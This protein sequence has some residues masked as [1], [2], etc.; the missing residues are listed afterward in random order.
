MAKGFFAK[1]KDTYLQAVFISL[2]NDFKLV[3]YCNS[4]WAGAWIIRKTHM[5]LFFLWESAAFIWPS[6]SNQL[7]R[8]LFVKLSIFSIAICTCFQTI[9][10]KN[11]LKKL[12]I[13]RKKS[14]WRVYGQQ[15]DNSINKE[16]CV[17]WPK[18]A[19]RHKT[20]FHLENV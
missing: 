8:S 20:S 10:Q 13:Y 6:R 11:L 17:P 12:H 19:N 2:S 9:R 7:F 18:Q 1:S 4:Y 5:G 3:G 16:S 14:Q 15:L